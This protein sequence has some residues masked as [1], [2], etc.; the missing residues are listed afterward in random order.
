[1]SIYRPGFT[2]LH[3]ASLGWHTGYETVVKFGENTDVDAATLAEDV[4]NGGGTYTGFPTGA[5]EALTVTSTSDADTAVTGAGCRTLT[6]VGLDADGYQVSET[7][8]MGGIAGTTTSST[9]TRVHRAYG[10]SGGSSAANVGVI[11]ITHA[12]TT[13]NVF[14]VIPAGYS[15]T[16]QAT[17][18][19]PVDKSA[20]LLGGRVAVSN[21][22]GSAQEAD[23]TMAIRLN[24]AGI[25]RLTDST[26]GTT[27]TPSVVILQ[28]GQLLPPLCD[29]KARVMGATADN[30]HVDVSFELL[31]VPT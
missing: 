28:V 15:Q 4:W 20:L 5:A 31:L 19:V 24:G 13:A 25:W 11:T 1:M 21:A 17:Y 26:M 23:V 3:A 27:A 12:V 6:I 2:A 16:R 18:T 8:N 22:A 9:W 29:L 10:A 7:V 30:L 14:S